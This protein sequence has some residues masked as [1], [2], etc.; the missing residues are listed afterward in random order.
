[1]IGA[2]HYDVTIR[3][4]E[5]GYDR[6]GWTPESGHFSLAASC[7]TLDAALALA[8]E[9]ADSVIT[10]FDDPFGGLIVM[11]RSGRSVFV[12]VMWRPCVDAPCS[13]AGPCRGGETSCHRP[14]A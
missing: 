10:R 8:S 4:S 1:M 2:E 14:G 5:V 6:M 12:Q 11:H 7:P 3:D 13:H 9:A